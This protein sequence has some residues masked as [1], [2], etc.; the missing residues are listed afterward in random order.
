MWVIHTAIA[1][2]D[3]EQIIP[4]I[5]RAR[6]IAA[7]ADLSALA[8]IIA[9][10]INLFISIIG[11]NTHQPETQCME[12]P[13]RHLNRSRIP[14]ATRCFAEF[15]LS[16]ANVLNVTMLPC[17]PEPQRRVFPMTALSSYRALARRRHTLRLPHPSLVPTPPV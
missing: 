12:Y 8:A 1:D 16:G 17:H 15:T 7:T 11:P 2:Y 9:T 3:Y 14:S 4:G 5:C 10:R 6:L 13:H